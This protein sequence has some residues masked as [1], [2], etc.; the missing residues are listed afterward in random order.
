MNLPLL[1]NNRGFSLLELIVT[2]V[3]AGILGAILVA[4]LGA[5]MTRSANPVVMVA[6][7]NELDMA[8]ENIVVE[9]K[10]RINLGTLNIQS[11]M[12]WIQTNYGAYVESANTR[13]IAFSSA[14][15]ETACA[16]DC[17]GLKLTLKKGDQRVVGLFTE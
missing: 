6:E 11:L 2:I 15:E 4:F 13:Y 3:I 8:M 17:R 9:Y 1:K 7:R 16:A 12:T 10:Q 5:S 14:N